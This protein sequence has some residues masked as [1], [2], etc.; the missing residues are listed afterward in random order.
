[1]GGIGTTAAGARAATAPACAGSTLG[2]TGLGAAGL[3]AA[4]FAAAEVTA[5]AVFG[6]GTCEVFATAACAT[7]AP[8]S[9][10]GAAPLALGFPLAA[11]PTG[12]DALTF[13]GFGDVF[14]LAGA[15]FF[16]GAA[17][18]LA[19]GFLAGA[20]WAVVLLK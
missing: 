2:V 20:L 1:L 11:L 10:A 14:L 17:D 7:L 12:A 18:F 19:A 6:S 13:A 15:D 8:F 16:A 5:L 4:G 9:G 3:G